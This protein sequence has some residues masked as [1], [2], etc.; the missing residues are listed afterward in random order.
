MD[1]LQ[2][3][4]DSGRFGEERRKS[5]IARRDAQDRGQTTYIGLP[6]K[7]GHGR[8]RTTSSSHCVTCNRENA[9]K[10][11]AARRGGAAQEARARGDKTY[12]GR[13]CPY[14]HGN[15]RYASNY[16]CVVC[17]KMN[18]KDWRARVKEAETPPP[19]KPDWLGTPH[20]FEDDP[21]A[22]SLADR[23]PWKRGPMQIII[24]RGVA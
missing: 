23:R 4:K 14:G 24:D 20:D 10:A 1:S 16:L 5:I 15:E 3:I 18:L 11:N 7:H 6:C 12:Q 9:K 17:A 8:E 2:A 19:E 22:N 21:R 13:R